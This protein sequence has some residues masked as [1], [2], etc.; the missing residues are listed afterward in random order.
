[1]SNLG[2]CKKMMY[3][4]FYSIKNIGFQALLFSNYDV[5]RSLTLLFFSTHGGLTNIRQSVIRK[6]RLNRV[7]G[8]TLAYL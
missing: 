7:F 5:F 1:M 4:A 8:S 6:I 3:P 2:K